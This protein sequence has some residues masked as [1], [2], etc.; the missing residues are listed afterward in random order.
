MPRGTSG[1]F[2]STSDYTNWAG[3]KTISGMDISMKHPL[4]SVYGLALV[5]VEY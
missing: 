5:A 3:V 2:T 1:C 4:V